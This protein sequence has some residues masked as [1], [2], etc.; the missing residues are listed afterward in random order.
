[1]HSFL[2]AFAA[3]QPECSVL[4]VNESSGKCCLTYDLLGVVMSACRKCTK[5]CGETPEGILRD[6]HIW[7]SRN[8][9]VIILEQK[10][11]TKAFSGSST[12]VHTEARIPLLI[13][14]LCTVIPSAVTSPDLSGLNRKALSLRWGRKCRLCRFTEVNPSSIPWRTSSH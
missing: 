13:I 11:Q 1:M 3:L 4:Y 5:I 9:A 2:Q 6:F 7:F 8:G 10:A 14:V 12:A